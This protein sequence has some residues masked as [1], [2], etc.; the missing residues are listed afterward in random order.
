MTYKFLRIQNARIINDTIVINF[1]LIGIFGNCFLN[2][3]NEMKYIVEY[4]IRII[5]TYTSGLSSNA[6]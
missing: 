4:K 2:M 1:P 3:S 5:D 6:L